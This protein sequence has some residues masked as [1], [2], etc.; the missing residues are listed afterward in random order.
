MIK[1]FSVILILTAISLGASAQAY[2]CKMPN[3]SMQ[4]SDQPCAAGTTARVVQKEHISESQYRS[5]T[6]WINRES[7]NLRRKEQAEAAAA[8]DAQQREA[9]AQ[10]Q[11]RQEML[12][13]Q[14]I[15]DRQQMMRKIDQAALAA[16]RAEKA[17]RRAQAA[18]NQAAINSGIR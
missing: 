13:Q 3:G 1:H 16:E 2:K 8:H 11:A 5:S 7:A 18:S 6:E 15:N 4:F 14:E 10:A 12:Q 17:A 9:V